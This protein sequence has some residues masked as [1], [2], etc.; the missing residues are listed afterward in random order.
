TVKVWHKVSDPEYHYIKRIV[1]FLGDEPV[2]EKT[3]SRQQANEYQEETF[4]FSEKPLQKGDPV[5]V[6]ASCSLFG[7]K[8]VDLVWQG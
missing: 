3:Y 2:A 4:T 8:T 6:Q 7:K 5:K 1:V